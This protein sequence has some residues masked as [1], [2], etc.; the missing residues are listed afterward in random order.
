MLSKIY[1]LAACI[2][3]AT[4]AAGAMSQTPTAQAS[5]TAN[6]AS[7]T[8]LAGSLTTGMAASVI[9]AGSCETTYQLVCTDANACSS[10]GLTVSSQKTK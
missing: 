1:L 3:G 6:T 4:A 9:S 5:G 8:I 7:A 2:A 10:S